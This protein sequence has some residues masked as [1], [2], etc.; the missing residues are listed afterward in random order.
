MPVVAAMRLKR[1]QSLVAQ[2]RQGRYGTHAPVVVQRIIRGPLSPIPD[3]I[4]GHAI[5]SAHHMPDDR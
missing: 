5:G 3:A 2:S 4:H 1:I